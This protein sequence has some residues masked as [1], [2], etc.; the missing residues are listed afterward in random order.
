M[1]TVSITPARKWCFT[2]NNYTDDHV[3]LLSTLF[4]DTCKYLIFGREVGANG[5]PHLQGFAW[6]TSQRSLA[7]ARLA[8]GPAHMTKAKGTPAQNRV[9]C[10]KD[11]DFEE[12]GELAQV[13]SQGKR[14]DFVDLKDWLLAFDGYPTDHEML[15]YNPSLWGRNRRA[16]ADFRRMLC[17]PPVLVE[18]DLRGWQVDLALQLAAPPDARSILFVVDALGGKGKTWFQ[19]KLLLEGDADVQLLM[20]GKRDDMA[21]AVQEGKKI[22][23]INV[24]RGQMEYLQYCV[25]EMLKDGVVH[26][27]KYESQTKFLA[28]CHV[29]VF[30]NEFPDMFRLTED[31]YLIKDL[32]MEDDA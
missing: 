3:M 19:K 23:L 2:L 27:P 18:G 26:S 22:Y 6:F 32:S 24:A 25:L 7:A 31:R 10:S 21:Y 11:G 9:Y 15:E 1:P 12:F 28:P 30:C 17:R 16:C 4:P 8:I 20:T 29:V 13:T 14:S 5:T